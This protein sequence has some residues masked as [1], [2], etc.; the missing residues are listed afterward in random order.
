MYSLAGYGDMIK[1][2]VRMAAH[3]RALRAVVRPGCVVADVGAGTGVM[4]LL[5][6][7]L[8]AG[9]VYAIEPAD[10]IE[11]ARTLAVANGFAD[12]IVFIQD[13]STRVT[14]PQRADVVVADLRGI[15]PWFGQNVPAV[16]DARDRLLAPGGTLIPQRDTIWFGVVHAPE[17][18]G[19]FTEAWRDNGLGLD[20][21]PAERIL[22]NNWVKG[23]ADPEQFV[24]QPRRLAALDYA[25]TTDV[26]L[27]V[28]TTS[29]VIRPATAHG[30]NAWFD[31]VLTGAIGFSNAPDQ[32]KL[33]Y[34]QAFFPWPAPV[35]LTPGDRVTVRLRAQLVGDDYVWNWD[36]TV[37]AGGGRVKASFRQSTF[38]GV[39]RSP[40]AWRKG[41]AGHVPDLG[42]EGCI[43]RLILSLMDGN[44]PC[45]AIA[46]RV[47]ASQP[48]RFPAW[49]D[50]LAR[51]GELSK[52]Y[53]R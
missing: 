39:P 51:V 5:A 29:D 28:Q 25:T 16:L 35:E 27:D 22:L 6:C 33:L 37:D 1:D 3:E 41:A 46:R 31:A 24:S 17:L 50:A 45:A 20:L 32:P 21:G 8:G 26:N 12:R 15:L 49:E 47:A 13:L 14:L 23:F 38:L 48:D 11:V 43:D 42:E 2:R 9:R 34:G 36:T 19:R 40:A 30:F 10:A 44:Q 4:S 7:R 53:G 52:R 18:Y